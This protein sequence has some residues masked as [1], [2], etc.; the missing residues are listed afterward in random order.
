MR[1]IHVCAWPRP[2]HGRSMR[3]RSITDFCQR[4]H[5]AQPSTARHGQST[6]VESSTA[7][8]LERLSNAWLAE[9]VTGTDRTSSAYHSSQMRDT[10]AQ[11]LPD[12]PQSIVSSHISHY[13]PN[14][15]LQLCTSSCP[16]AASLWSTMAASERKAL[17][18]VNYFINSDLRWYIKD[19]PA[20]H[21]SQSTAE[22]AESEHLTDDEIASL[23]SEANTVYRALPRIA[24]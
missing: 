18:A 19:L 14:V 13:N 2:R 16:I 3:Q 5:R 17:Q 12:S 8:G 10:A 15:G 24:G 1:L 6:A 23:D 4:L 22:L 9:D 21:T 7:L 11:T 20:I